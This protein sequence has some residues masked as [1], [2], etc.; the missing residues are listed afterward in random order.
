[1]TL[2]TSTIHWSFQTG[3]ITPPTVFDQGSAGVDGT[4]INTPTNFQATGRS[5][6][7]GTLFNGTNQFCQV[8]FTSIPA[9]ASTFSLAGYCR[10]D[11]STDR[12]VAISVGGGN[13]TAFR[14]V[15]VERLTDNR[16]SFVIQGGT[17][18]TERI[19]NSTITVAN[20]VWCT[21]VCSWD[22]TTMRLFVR[23]ATTRELVTLAPGA[24]TPTYDSA[25]YF[26]IGSQYDV[27]GTR[28]MFGVIGDGRWWNGIVLTYAQEWEYSNLFGPLV[29]LIMSEQDP[30]VMTRIGSSPSA[31]VRP[32]VLNKSKFET[33]RDRIL[34]LI[35]EGA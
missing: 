24:T 22:N 13:P 3:T 34:A 31:A 15:W 19:L 9:P 1:M 21:I 23:T 5:G 32:L 4:L 8:P 17:G 29:P 33:S 2:P 12:R 16:I 10:F 27:D 14:G 6:V 7:V 18:P 30:L 26:A 20:G 35:G 28:D 25:G 11:N